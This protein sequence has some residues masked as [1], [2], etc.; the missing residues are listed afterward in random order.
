VPS[1]VLALIYY[2]T[3]IQM[4]STVLALIYYYTEI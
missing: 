3:G 1:I 2:L 4:P